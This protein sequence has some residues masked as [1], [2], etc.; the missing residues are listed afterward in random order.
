MITNCITVIGA[1]IPLVVIL[2]IFFFRIEG[3]LTRIE[4]DVSWIKK[5]LP[6]CQQ[7]LGKN[8]P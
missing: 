8:T 3:R 7:S 1:L 5:G 2:I 4:T 6:E